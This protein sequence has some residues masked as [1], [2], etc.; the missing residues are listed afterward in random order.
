[1][2]VMNKKMRWDTDAVVRFCQMWQRGVS[3]KSMA[4]YFKVSNYAIRERA[5]KIRAEAV[6]LALRTRGS[7]DDVELPEAYVSGPLVDWDE[8]KR[9]LG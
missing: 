2:G 7:G 4:E 9:R 6:D 5:K 3:V 8:V 1:M